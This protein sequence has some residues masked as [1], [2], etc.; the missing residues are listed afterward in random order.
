MKTLILGT[1]LRGL[2][3][4]ARTSLEDGAEVIVY[5]AEA[6]DPPADLVGRVTVLPTEW[7]VEHLKGVDRVVASPWFPEVAPPIS[8]AL[9]AG[10]DII[11]EAGFALEHLDTPFVA[12][13]GTNGKTTVVE[14]ITDMLCTSGVRAVGAGNVGV[15]VSDVR[16][17]DTDL[18]VLELSSYQ[19]RFLGRSVPVAA[20]LLN[21]APDHL[22]WHGTFAAYA[23]RTWLA[24][25]SSRS[26]SM[27][28]TW[29]MW[30]GVPD[31]PSC[32]VRALPFQRVETGLST[33]PS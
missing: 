22:D 20:A 28:R 12:V 10:I 19:L 13:T 21:I 8:D 23:A 30:S 1:N 33:A 3:H 17:D 24:T 26:T 18:L 27:T 5:D 6:A 14:L 25:R 16:R 7:A 29:S 9:A 11:T 2:P 32:P 4:A 31:V 15:A